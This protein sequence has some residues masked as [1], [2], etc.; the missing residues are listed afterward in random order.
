M[1]PIAILP[2]RICSRGK[3]STVSTATSRAV[4]PISR[5]ATCTSPPF[6]TESRPSRVK[7]GRMLGLGRARPL[8]SR[9]IG[10]G[11]P[12]MAIATT[13]RLGLVGLVGSNDLLDEFV[14]DDI[15]FGEIHEANIRNPPQDVLDF[16]QP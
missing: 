12:S 7:N 1:S 14:A 3:R 15:P 5:H 2:I 6:A 11:S 13:L 10:L 8:R 9:S 16:H 4:M